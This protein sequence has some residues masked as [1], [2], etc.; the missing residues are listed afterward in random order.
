MTAKALLI[1]MMA[2]MA[3]ATPSCTMVAWTAAQFSPPQKVKALYVVPADKK[4]LIFVDDLSNP[5]SYPPV[6]RELAE[7]IGR[8]FAENKVASVTISYERVLDLMA[9]EK[10]FNDMGVANVGR[11]VGAD[12]VLFVDI[13]SFK[14]REEEGSPLWEGNLGVSVRWVDAW[15]T[16]KDSARIWP[17]DAAEYGVPAVG[18]PVKEEPSVDYGAEMARILATRMADRIAKL[19]YDHEVPATDIEEK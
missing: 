17:K 9:T 15:A 1:A 10:K 7:A 16:K 13:K 14:L 5:V 19:F 3:V 8:Q 11:K 2:A 4:V 6:K 12:L 18:M